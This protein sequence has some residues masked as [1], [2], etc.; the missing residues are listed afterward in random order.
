MDSHWLEVKADPSHGDQPPGS[1]K[2]LPAIL[3]VEA[4][5][6]GDLHETVVSGYNDDAIPEIYQSQIIVSVFCVT[7]TL[8]LT[9]PAICNGA[10]Y[11]RG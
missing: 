11:I 8:M 3:T 2:N 4:M 6:P 1:E 7:R 9:G 10:H 5:P